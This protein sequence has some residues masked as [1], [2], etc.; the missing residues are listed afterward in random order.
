MVEFL[1]GLLA[2]LVAAEI[3]EWLPRLS[4]YILKHSVKKAPPELSERLFEEWHAVLDNTPGGMSKLKC[5]VGF[6]LATPH[7]RHEFYLPDEPFSPLTF[8]AIR[9]VDVIISS[10]GL[11][12]FYPILLFWVFVI[13]SRKVIV[14]TEIQLRNDGSPFRLI[15]FRRRVVERRPFKSSLVN[16]FLAST[17][18]H[19]FPLLFNVLIG[20]LSLVGREPITDP[21]H[22]LPD[23]NDSAISQFRP[24]MYIIDPPY[25]NEYLK[26]PFLNYFRTLRS[27]M[28]L[29]S[30]PLSD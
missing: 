30:T 8:R 9:A 27:I 23:R 29:G 6:L 15:R 4:F 21:I 20:D 2:N 10:L 12:F 22:P 17:T 13:V 18:M 16:R 28:L 25:I 5:A 3:G 26:S 1:L 14:E 24:G 7:I 11:L 19:I